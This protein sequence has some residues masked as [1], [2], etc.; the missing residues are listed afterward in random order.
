[1]LIYMALE[2]GSVGGKGKI[3]FIS[4][5]EKNQMLHKIASLELSVQ[6][7]YT[8]LRILEEKLHNAPKKPKKPKVQ[9]T[10]AQKVKQREYMRQYKA[11]KLAEK[12][13]KLEQAIA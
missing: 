1:M 6:G 5:K 11:R 13:A 2:F 3:M 7:L 10:E 12:K 9:K 4:T 8:S